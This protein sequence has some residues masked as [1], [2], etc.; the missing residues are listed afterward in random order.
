MKKINLAITG[1]M[2]RMGQQLIKSANKNSVFKIVA[3]TENK[4]ISKKILGLKPALN[5]KEAFKNANVIID[6]TIPKCTLEILKIAVKQKKK[7]IIGTTG[8]TKKEEILIKKFSKK[9]P[10]LKAGNMS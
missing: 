7:V 1:C 4:K 2:G 8:F 5:S 3:L 10:I 9:I 6:F